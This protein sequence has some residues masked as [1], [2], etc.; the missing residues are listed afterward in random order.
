MKYF[1][2]FT[3]FYSLLFTANSQIT[4]Y[5]GGYT[6]ATNSNTTTTITTID[7]SSYTDI[8]I[9]VDYGEDGDMDGPDRIR[10]QYSIDGG[11]FVDIVNVGNDICAGVCS[12][13]G[14]GSVTLL[15]GTS[16]IAIRTIIKCDA[17]ETWWHDNLIVTGIE[18]PLPIEL[19]Y[20]NVILKDDNVLVEWETLSEI[21]N[22]YFE[23]ENSL[24]GIYFKPI[25]FVYG[26]LN[27]TSP[28]TYS[29]D[30]D[31]FED[32]YYRLKQVDIDGATTYSKIIFLNYRDL[33]KMVIGIFD[34]N[35]I[36]TTMNNPGVIIIL[37]NDGTSIK[38]LNK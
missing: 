33:S 38:Q 15:N 30:C 11:A 36:P 10:I 23:V 20:F 4:L 31:I 25:Y 1:I 19:G 12:G 21:N 32:C 8:S 37:Y 24:D 14:S 22:D 35:G 18:D 3:V 5:S 16:T 17:A 28:I 9:T 26:S 2:M 6:S 27:S 34:L 13:S 29:V 7:I